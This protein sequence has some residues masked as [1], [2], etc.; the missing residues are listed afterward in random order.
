MTLFL[1]LYYT[2]IFRISQE[3]TVGKTRQTHEWLL[4]TPCQAGLMAMGG[5]LLG[6]AR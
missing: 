1:N 5:P 2:L 3:A 6:F 4:F